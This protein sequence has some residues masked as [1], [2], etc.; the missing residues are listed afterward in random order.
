MRLSPATRVVIPPL[1]E[2]LA[3]LRHF[4]AHFAAS[5][6]ADGELAELRDRAALALGLARGAPLALV[7]ER[8]A[9]AAADRL[10]LHLPQAAFK[11]LLAYGWP[12][13]LRE[14]ATVMRN[15]VTFTLVAAADALGAGV[16]VRSPRLQID[17]G[18][19][20]ELLAGAGVS[21]GAAAT[22]ASP[23][24]ELDAGRGGG[25]SA[26]P[27]GDGAASTASVPTSGAGAGAVRV[28]VQPGRTLNAVAQDV[29]RQY[30]LALFSATR[31]SFAEMAEI[32][33]GDAKRTRS[34]RL[35]FNQL[36][37]KVRQLRRS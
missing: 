11:Q 33:L 13:N 4:A 30:M 31:G 35:R 25:S 1:R 27:A 34:V 7:F 24:R 10:A 5:A 23:A 9:H 21:A 14:L 26:W 18:L 12:G 22:R 15:L 3:D 8:G 20:A 37:L 2:R 16:R 6:V 36:G 29:E 28:Q 17:P 19:V 32:L